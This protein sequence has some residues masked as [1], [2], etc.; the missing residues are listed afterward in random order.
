MP[1]RQLRR[2]PREQR[3]RRTTSVASGPLCR[4]APPAARP[5]RHERG[6][7]VGEPARRSRSPS[8]PGVRPPHRAPP[9][10]VGTCH[11]RVGT[12]HRRMGT[13]HPRVGT[14]HRSQTAVARTRRWPTRPQWAPTASRHSVEQPRGVPPA[15]TQRSPR[16]LPHRAGTCHRRARS[17]RQWREAV[18]RQGWPTRPQWAPTA[19]RHSVEQPRG[20]PPA[21][22]RPSPRALPHRAGTCHRR[23]ATCHQCRATEVGTRWWPTRPQWAPTASRHSA[24]QR[25]GVP[26][27]PA[28]RSPR[29]LP[30]RVGTCHRRVGS[31][32]RWRAEATRSQAAPGRPIAARGA[33]RATARSSATRA[34]RQAR[35]AAAHPARSAVA[36]QGAR[37]RSGRRT[38]RDTVGRGGGS[39]VSSGAGPRTRLGVPSPPPSPSTRPPGTVSTTAWPSVPV[40][41]GERQAVSSAGKVVGRVISVI[42]AASERWIGGRKAHP[43][44]PGP[45]S[46]ATARPASE[47]VAADPVGRSSARDHGQRI[48]QRSSA[49]RVLIWAISRT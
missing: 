21:P 32:H 44:G 26:P 6:V 10:R 11:R 39:S 27:G 20:D 24:E 40:K 5:V 46:G 42:G 3:T 2:P 37:P 14:C 35:R 1:D 38:D 15:P 45:G 29:A 47:P 28:Q 9:H 4:V 31:C 36:R 19:S 16:A 43:I 30:H 18:R 8:E 12:S 41:V 13:C 33:C 17:R 22:T 7:A 23:A 34:K 49:R 48:A 25:P